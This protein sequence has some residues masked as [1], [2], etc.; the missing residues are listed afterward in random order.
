MSWYW[1]ST[2]SEGSDYA[3]GVIFNSEYITE[4]GSRTVGA[5]IRPVIPK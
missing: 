3:E 1:S 5:S 2:L 4:G